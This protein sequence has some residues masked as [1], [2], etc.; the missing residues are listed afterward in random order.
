MRGHTTYACCPRPT[1]SRTRSQ[2]RS[3]YLGLSA[4]GTTNEAMGERPAGSSV[5]V[6]VSRSP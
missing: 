3:R 4:A 6:E 2:A 1:S 5:S